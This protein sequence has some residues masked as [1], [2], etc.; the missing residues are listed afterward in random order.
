MKFKHYLHI[1]DNEEEVIQSLIASGFTLK[2]NRR[3][4]KESSQH[5]I[6]YEIVDSHLANNSVKWAGGLILEKLIVTV[7]LK[8]SGLLYLISRFR[9]NEYNEDSIFIYSKELTEELLQKVFIK[10]CTDS[11]VMV[12]ILRKYNA[13]YWKKGGVV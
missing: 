2:R 10:G 11:K 12:N 8:E 13:V 4:S 3:Y 5:N 6:G 1:T 7:P 9:P